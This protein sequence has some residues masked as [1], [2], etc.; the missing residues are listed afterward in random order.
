MSNQMRVRERRIG[1]VSNQKG[2]QCEWHR[3]RRRRRRIWEL[4]ANFDLIKFIASETLIEYTFLFV[5]PIIDLTG[6][7]E[8]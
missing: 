4:V 8:S 7:N 3:V 2:W 5:H 6:K 1:I